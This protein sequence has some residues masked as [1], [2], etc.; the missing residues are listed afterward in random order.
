M[1]R[2]DERNKDGHKGPIKP[3]WIWLAVGVFMCFIAF[4]TGFDLYASYQA[5]IKDAQKQAQTNSFLVSEW[6]RESFST[7]KYIVRDVGHSLLSKPL[8]VLDSK[9]ESKN[10]QNYLKSRVSRDS[11]I[12]HLSVLNK[13]CQLINTSLD[14]KALINRIIS[15]DCQQIQGD[16]QGEFY[17]SRLL[18]S[19]T[20]QMHISISYAVHN[21]QKQRI[22]Y[23]LLGLE[24]AMFQQWLERIQEENM[25]FSLFDFEQKLLARKPK[26]VDRIGLKLE[27]KKL[28]D[29][30]QSEQLELLTFRLKSP[31]DGIDRIWNFRKIP[32]FPFVIVIGI[33][34]NLTLSA[35]QI[36]LVYYLLGNIALFLAIGFA[37]R[38]FIF[39][40]SSASKMEKLA[41][42]DPLTGLANRRKFYEIARLRL[43]D[44]W[45]NKQS[46]SLI[47]IDIDHFKRI[48]D[49]FGHDVGD[50]VLKKFA[51][52]VKEQ[53][54]ATDLL[55][56]WGG[57][58]F[59]LLLPDTSYFDASRLAERL[60]EKIQA[61]E[62]LPNHEITISLGVVIYQEPESLTALLKRADEY[63]YLAKEQGRN[64]VISKEG[65]WEV[66]DSIA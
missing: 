37:A 50:E 27:N 32:G 46:L 24:L 23:V 14:N 28:A 63:L 30:I 54:R 21:A 12:L 47:L 10:I 13:D 40:Q 59:V 6:I 34:T 2:F 18:L 19:D 52:T 58:E 65:D 41:M 48:N 66:K 45:R 61:C 60:R 22:G 9:L 15:S 35:W 16:Y 38:E 43:N 29:F 20:Q 11:G 3:K 42:I 8:K 4:L 5:V 1:Q 64:R 7:P 17:I 62:M 49:K 44:R 31:I 53:M 56:R 25:V 36:K 51:D 57:E 39:A 33:Q 55:A 26:V